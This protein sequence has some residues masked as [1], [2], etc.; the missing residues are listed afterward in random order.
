MIDGVPIGADDLLP[1]NWSEFGEK[2]P[3]RFGWHRTRES[4][5]ENVKI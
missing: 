4:V 3:V 2:F 5:D 1:G